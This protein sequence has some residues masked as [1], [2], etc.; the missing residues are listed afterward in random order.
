MIGQFSLPEFSYL[1]D[2]LWHIEEKID[3]TNIRVLFDG[4]NIKFNG[5]T[6][7]AQ[8]PV[9]LYD[10][11]LTMFNKES[12]SKVFVDN[13]NV[14]L[15]GEGYGRK[16]QAIGSSYIPDDVSFILFDVWI[17]GI[18][19]KRDDVYYIADKLNIK[20]VPYLGSTTLKDAELKVT[21]GFKSLIGDCQAEG[22]V[23]RP[24]VELQSRMGNRI[25]TKIKTRDF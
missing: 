12:M 16:I 19:L 24:L 1:Y 11:L 22:V 3:G 25:I 21:N 2:N 15:Y 14:C 9:F 17:N 23:C 10:K 8:M 20:H 4:V 5:K 18:W 7:N 13:A 6:D